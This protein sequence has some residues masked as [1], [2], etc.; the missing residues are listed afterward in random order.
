MT[1]R[2]HT[3]AGVLA[4][5]IPGGAALH[6]PE[7][8]GAEKARVDEC[9]RSGWV[10]TAGPFVERFE[11]ALA[12]Y[13]GANH[14]IACVNGTAALHACLLLAGTR[15]GDEVIIPSLT[16]VATANAVA[17][18]GAT[19]HFADSDED[20]LGLDPAKLA[21][22]LEDI[23]HITK[24]N[25]FNRRSG[26]RIAAVVCMHAFGHAADLDRLAET[27]RHYKLPLIEDAAES[28]GSFY[29][30]RHTG[31]DGVLS[32][33]SFNGNKIVTSGGGGAIL[34]GGAE[35][36]EKARHLTT[37]AKK[38]HPWMFE[39]DQVGF[40]YRL[41]N[42]N[43][44]LGLAQMERLEDFLTRKRRLAMRYKDAFAGVEGVRFFEEPED[45][46]SNYWLN[47]LLLERECAQHRD[48]AL[49]AA[50]EQGFMARPAWTPMHMLD[51]HKDCAR[52]NLDTAEDI[53]AR[54]INIPSSPAL[55]S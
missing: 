9:L 31:L 40:N 3:I 18:C 15:P 22:H 55:V 45:R 39:H 54:L 19:P 36:A 8:G 23:G 24:G 51:M 46:R 50:N 32:A 17:Y 6:E 49:K 10:S 14:A 53:F 26:N 4:Q 21:N 5:T 12:Q 34:T 27:C 48:A 38:P 28:L 7:I 20:T 42:I 30:G 25:C 13:T 11:D 52:M 1:F 47:V 41:P 33:L 37:T 2:A 16:F 29:K 43:A 44:A 35:L